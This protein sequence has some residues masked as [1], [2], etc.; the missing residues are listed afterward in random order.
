MENIKMKSLEK[1]K[2]DKDLIEVIRDRIKWDA[3]LSNVDIFIEI[4]GGVV[5][6]SGVFDSTI[7]R[8]AV[9]NILRSTKGVSKF[10]DYTQINRTRQRS[11]K[12]IHRII[13]KQIE[14]FYLFNGETIEIKVEKGIIFY[15]GV[16]YRKILKAFAS[17][18]AWELS[19]VNDCVNSIKIAKPPLKKD[20]ALYLSISKAA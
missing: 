3:R 16:V 6:V 2:K 17:K 20:G 15:K 5:Q 13:K 12:E 7:R 4:K 19:G 18:I 10:R 1:N 9:L 8:R 11:D 14:E